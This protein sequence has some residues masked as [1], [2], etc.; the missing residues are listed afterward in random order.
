MA[1]WLVVTEVA[2]YLRCGERTVRDLMANDQ[3]PHVIF[4]GRALFN[5][6]RI[7]DWLLSKEKKVQVLAEYRKD[8]VAE[9]IKELMTP[10]SDRPKDKFVPR[11]GRNLEG[12]LE[13][14]Y[15]EAPGLAF[16]SWKVYSQLSHWCH[17]KRHADREKWVQPRAEEISQLLFGKIIDRV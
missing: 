5:T 3:I 11:L 17:P 1:K 14:V 16:L 4:A 15:P 10:H 13:K 7:D 2:D 6:D 9:L 12:E 8:R